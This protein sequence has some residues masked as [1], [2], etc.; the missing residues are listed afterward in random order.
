MKRKFLQ[1]CLISGL[2]SF[3]SCVQGD[4]DDLED[5]MDEL[6][7]Q[8]TE[9]EKAQQ[10]ALLAAIAEMQAALATLESDIDADY[11]VLLSNLTDLNDVVENN[12]NAIYYGNLLTDA[13]Y[14]AFVAQGAEIVTGKVVITNDDH[15]TKLAKLLM[16][17]GDL[18]IKGGVTV[19]LPLLE[20]VG[21]NLYIREVA[22]V[23]ATVTLTKLASIGGEFGIG[24]NSELKSVNAPELVLVYEGLYMM[25]NQKL[26][27]FALSSLDLVE[28]LD[29]NG[30]FNMYNSFDLSATDVTGDATVMAIAG[31]SEITLGK[32]G[33]NISIMDF[34]MV[35]SLS[36][37]NDII[38]GDLTI[39]GLRDIETINM[40]NLTEIKKIGWS[41][42][43]NLSV[44]GLYPPSEGGGGGIGPFSLKATSNG[45]LAWT[46]NI[47]TIDGD[48]ELAGN[49]LTS[50]DALN[51]V[52]T[53][54]GDIIFQGNGNLATMLV[55]EA[56]TSAGGDITVDDK[57]KVFDGFNSLETM[58]YNTK[59]TIV[60]GQT[61]D[62]NWEFEGECLV[63]GFGALTTANTIEIGLGQTVE[64][65][66]LAAL[67]SLTAYDW[68]T[69]ITIKMQNP[70]YQGVNGP[71]QLCS[72]Q[73]FLENSVS[74]VYASEYWDYQQ[75]AVDPM[76]AIPAL[77]ANCGGGGIGIGS[78]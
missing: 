20:T 44:Q 27:D 3:G 61:M 47:I 16:V 77:T 64:F 38:L 11:Q 7:E 45:L 68:Q 30:G 5:R 51:N 18:E 10:D 52:E 72:M 70:E 57:V 31:V 62:S 2:L 46:N 54:G 40:P 6:T 21:S 65:T 67:T 33:A 17:G 53:V 12:K 19:T 69:G 50:M 23:D 34:E 37:A 24:Y 32:V 63:Q 25:D 9:L 71:V 78:N 41:E 75:Q 66:A 39:S 15:V 8:V 42:G 13:E 22:D 59:L 74:A 76:T 58:G 55:M 35:A 14:D 26:T 56:L 28:E 29:L 36:I 49:N 4:I 73:S 48:V 60:C 43:G 1:L